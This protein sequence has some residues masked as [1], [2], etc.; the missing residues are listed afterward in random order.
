MLE[1]NFTIQGLNDEE[2]LNSRKRFA[3][4]KLRSKKKVE[5]LIVLKKKSG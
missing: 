4:T 3:P 5:F 1:N 2:V